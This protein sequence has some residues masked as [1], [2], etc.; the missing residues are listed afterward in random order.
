M[1]A[2]AFRIGEERAELETEAEELG[3]IQRAAQN[4][5]YSVAGFEEFTPVTA[6]LRSRIPRGEKSG[7]LAGAAR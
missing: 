1:F 3:G 6:S 7:P 4:G 2:L 5:E